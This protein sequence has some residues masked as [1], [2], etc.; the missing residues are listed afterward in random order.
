L[1]RAHGEADRRAGVAVEIVRVEE[2]RR[3]PGIDGCEFSSLDRVRQTRKRLAH[4]R[5]PIT[6]DSGRRGFLLL[7]GREYVSFTV[8]HLQSLA[9]PKEQ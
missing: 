1:V 6:L 3:V 4:I 2:W 8:E 7:I 9:F 5:E